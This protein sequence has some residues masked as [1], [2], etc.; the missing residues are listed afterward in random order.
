MSAKANPINQQD[1]WI[2]A[3]VITM[4]KIMM[5]I[6]KKY[7]NNIVTKIINKML[8]VVI[9]LNKPTWLSLSTI[10]IKLFIFPHEQ[11]NI[12]HSSMLPTP[13]I[14]RAKGH[15]A[16]EKIKLGFILSSVHIIMKVVTPHL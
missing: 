15:K 7:K 8:T 14:L 9:Y 2:K 6:I 3:L 16:A 1:R 13:N 4:M 12:N 5:M 11:D 10:Y